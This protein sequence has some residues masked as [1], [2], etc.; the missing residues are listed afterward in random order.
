MELEVV[1]GAAD[2][3]AL[4]KLVDVTSQT[5]QVHGLGHVE[6]V[7][8]YL[9]GLAALVVGVGLDDR[10]RVQT[11]AELLRNPR[12]AAARRAR[13]ADDENLHRCKK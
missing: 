2:G 3:V 4:L 8:V 5:V 13:D 7:S 9:V 6:V 10:D 12:L 11:L 1:D